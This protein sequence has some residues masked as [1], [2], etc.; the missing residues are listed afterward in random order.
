MAGCSGAAVSGSDVEPAL[1]EVLERPVALQ[2][3]GDRSAGAFGAPGAHQDFA[4]VH[5]LTTGTLAHLRAL[6]PDIAWDARRFRPN[7]VFS[8]LE[9]HGEDDLHELAGDGVTLRAVKPC[10]R[11]KITTIDQ[12]TGTVS[13]PVMVSPAFLT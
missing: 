6:H 3:C 8:G 9:P 7:L 10:T 11:C 5:L 4:P 2:R 12:K 1:S 13:G